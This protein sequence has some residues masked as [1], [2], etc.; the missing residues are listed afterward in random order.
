MRFWRWFRD[1]IG[2]EAE[3]LDDTKEEQKRR[4]LDLFQSK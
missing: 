3:L 1:L 4:V 2:D